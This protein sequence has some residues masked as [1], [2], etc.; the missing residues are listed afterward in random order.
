MGAV[1]R[2]L[3]ALALVAVT[4]CGAT[5]ESIKSAGSYVP[6]LPLPAGQQVLNLPVPAAPAPVPAGAVQCVSGQ[7]EGI[8]L[9]GGVAAGNSNQPLL[10][11]NKGTSGCFM[12]GFVD[13]TILDRRG[14]VLVRGAGEA[15]RGTFFADPPVTDVWMPAGTPP[16][17]HAF[18]TRDG[19]AG[20]AFMNMSW[21]DCRQPLAA[22]MEVRLPGRG[23]S[24]QV[25]Y[26]RE[27][28]T[29][30]ACQGDTSTHAD[31]RRAPVSPAGQWPY[32]DV[33]VQLTVPRDG[34]RG[35]QITY[36][37][38]VTNSGYTDYA[39]PPCPDY[40][41]SIRGKQFVV[42]Y[43]L[44]CGPVSTLGP[45]A[46]ATFEMRYVIPPATATGATEICWF[47]SDA[48]LVGGGGSCADVR[49]S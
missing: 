27:A 41:E 40:S 35:V 6:W 36:F 45:G 21:Y 44:N 31:L 49:I 4:A 7:L 47:L 30:P 1:G 3:V 14:R 42:S 8:G 13:I 10:F 16:L 22:A 28:S 18:Q 46:G 11:R 5:V 48:R 43:Q 24:F 2:A 39:M 20:Q 32:N 15:G 38:I 25:P 17:P 23:G 37:A 34:K 26:A 12:R 9:A 29:N 33:T 19:F